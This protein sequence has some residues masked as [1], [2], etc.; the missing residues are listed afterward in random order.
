M[1]KANGGINKGATVILLLMVLVGLAFGVGFYFYAQSMRSTIFL[2]NNNYEAGTTVT[3]DMFLM[4][5]IDSQTYKGMGQ[6]GD[7]GMY[8]S[9][10]QLVGYI[11]SGEKLSADVVAYM[12]VVDTM[13]VSTGGTG[14]ERRL[15]NDKVAVEIAAN[16]VNGLSGREVSVESRVNISSFYSVEDVMETDLLFQDVLVLDVVTDDDGNISS[17]YVELS[18]EDSIVLQHALVSESVSI[19]VLKPGS[20]TPITEG[21]EYR[22]VYSTNNNIATDNGSFVL[23]AQQP[24]EPA[25]E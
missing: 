20:Y 22:K 13:F 18:P 11:E 10:S 15:D 1:K 17:I 19:A 23:D 7:K 16:K 3:K 12:P 6:N 8:V 5:E 9:E 24:M 14:V 2:F 21:T 4:Q 25:A